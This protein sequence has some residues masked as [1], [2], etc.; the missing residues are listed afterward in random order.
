LSFPIIRA[1]TLSAIQHDS[2]KSKKMEKVRKNMIK[3]LVQDKRVFFKKGKGE[4]RP[5][6]S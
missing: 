3:I 2:T 1:L 5:K 4:A 6:E